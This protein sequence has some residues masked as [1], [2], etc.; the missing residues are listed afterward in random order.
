MNGGGEGRGGELRD[1][2]TSVMNNFST[3]VVVTAKEMKVFPGCHTDRFST[4][5]HSSYLNVQVPSLNK[6]IMLI[7]RRNVHMG[8]SMQSLCIEGTCIKQ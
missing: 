8:R 7:R 2:K 5:S 3:D 6:Y 1:H 4:N